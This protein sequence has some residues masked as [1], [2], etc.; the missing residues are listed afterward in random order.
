MADN[1]K[2][3]VF[4]CYSKNDKPKVM[5]LYHRLVSDGVDAWID[6]E[7]LIGGQNWDLEIRKAIRNTDAVVAC[8]SNNTYTKAGYVQKEILLALDIANEQPEGAIY[9]IPVRF[10][11]CQVRSELSKWHWVNLFDEA[12]YKKLIRS[13]RIRAESIGIETLPS[14]DATTSQFPVLGTVQENQHVENIEYDNDIHAENVVEISRS[15]LPKNI[16]SQELFALEVIGDSLADALITNGDI[17]VLAPSSR[18]KVRNGELVL[19]NLPRHKETTLKYFFKERNRYRLQPANHTMKP[20]FLKKDEPLEIMG[21]VVM[22]I[23]RK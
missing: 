1:R 11:E 13:L 3:K 23:R 18:E 6:E 22:V 5:E 12:G 10:E 17:V 9:L 16:N 15:L 4:L 21:K 20:I 7:N 19:I 14:A 2:L 8:L